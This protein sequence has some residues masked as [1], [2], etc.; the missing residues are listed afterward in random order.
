MRSYTNNERTETRSSGFTLIELLVVIAIIAI[1]AAILFPVFASAREKARQTSC[2]SNL[3]Q[4]GLAFTQYAQDYDESLPVGYDFNWYGNEGWGT[5]GLCGWPGEVLPYVKTLNVYTC[6]DDSAGNELLNDSNPPAGLTLWGSN[7]NALSYKA[8]GFCGWSNSAGWFANYSPLAILNSWMGNGIQGN[9]SSMSKVTAP[10]STILLFESH[11]DQCLAY[12]KINSSTNMS[13]NA[14]T[15]AFQQEGCVTTATG[16]G[17]GLGFPGTGW[18]NLVSS[19]NY[20]AVSATHSG[21]SN[22]LYCDG[23]VKTLNPMNTVTFGYY[24]QWNAQQ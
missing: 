2:S 11:A 9:S 21:M 24:G 19:N 5:G 13:S 6:P 3:K 8:N 20:G 16:V 14:C 23:H 15:S 4:L 22:F 1:L 18:G 10:S 12:G 17:D 7:G